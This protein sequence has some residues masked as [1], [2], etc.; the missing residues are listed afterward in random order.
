V[1]LRKEKGLKQGDLADTAK[2]SVRLLGDIERNNHPVPA[3]TITAI[4]AEL[5]VNPSD[6]TLSTPDAS[7]PKAESLL[8]LRAVRSATALS[9]LAEGATRYEWRLKIDPSAA[10]TADM[11]AVMKIIQRLVARWLMNPSG[12]LTMPPTQHL[13]SMEYVGDQFDNEKFGEISRLTHLQD[14]L[15]R[16]RTNGVNVIAGTYTH[17]WLRSLFEDETWH[18]DLI[19]VRVPGKTAAEIFE[20]NLVLSLRFVPCDVEEEVV[21]INTGPSLEEFE[22]VDEIPF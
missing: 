21:P 7:S 14:L 16:L 20:T 2:I 13:G 22:L 15:T 4:A 8:K 1:E 18:S 10:T 19:W 5:K 6:I 11:Q 3:T 17:S 9:A 12:L